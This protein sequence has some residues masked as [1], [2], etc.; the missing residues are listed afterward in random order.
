V[1]NASAFRAAGGETLNYIPALNAGA[2]HADAL[3]AL[4]RRDLLGASA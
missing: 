1:E 3:A 2:A 4:A